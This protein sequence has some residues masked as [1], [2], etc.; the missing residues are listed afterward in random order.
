MGIKQA[1]RIFICCAIATTAFANDKSTVV[2]LSETPAAVQKTI[3]ARVGDG[4]LDD[5][6]KTT[7]GE[8]TI[9]DVGLTAK[10]GQ[11]CDFTVAEDG[12]LMSTQVTLVETPAAVQ[13]SI[14]TLAKE[15]EVE[16]IDKSL[17]GLNV[18]YD[19]SLTTKDGREKGF[20]LDDDGTLLSMEISL[21]EAPEA[22]QKTVQAE[23][24]DGK[25]ESID[26]MFGEDG[27]TYDVAVTAKGGREKSFTV[28][29]D[30]KLVSR[31]V[32][33]EE[34]PA[35]VRK[36]IKERMGDGKVLRID[37]SL[38]KN[39]GVM[40]YEVQGR[41]DGKPFDFSVGPGGRFLGRDD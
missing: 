1:M 5:I 2:T 27:T 9:Y 41:K 6:N 4:E 21:A 7:E 36:T 18:T 8:E 25:L 29:E 12:T 11:D 39:K 15:G 24:A 40:P 32:T 10:G 28:A 31:Q 17:G 22:V 38:I 35:P 33:L 26:K 37:R 3:N 19:I 23:T 16:S 14:Q 20:T 13:K 34:A 30:G